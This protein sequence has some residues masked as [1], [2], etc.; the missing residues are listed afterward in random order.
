M[1]ARSPKVKPVKFLVCM[2]DTDHARIALRYA[3]SRVAKRG[4]SVVMVHV[5]DTDEAKS[6][7]LM[8]GKMLDEKRRQAQ[9]LMASLRAEANQ[10]GDVAI[11]ETVREGVI[12]EEILRTV[13]EDFDINILLLGMAPD[14]SPK[15]RRI[16]TWLTNQLGKR[17]QIPVMVVPGNLT[18][19]QIEELS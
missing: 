15:G 12:G 3:C 7:P 16:I 6:F 13:E 10:W 14:S 19:L 18:D 9:T 17:L 11:T 5:V 2:D 1:N 4:G 8:A